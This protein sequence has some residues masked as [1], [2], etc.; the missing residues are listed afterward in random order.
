MNAVE[1]IR[2]ALESIPEWEER[3]IEDVQLIEGFEDDIYEL[4]MGV[5]I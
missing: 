1:Q 2:M 5:E 3:N 4:T